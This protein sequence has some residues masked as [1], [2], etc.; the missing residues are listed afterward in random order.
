MHPLVC[1]LN[2]GQ[3]HSSACVA[4]KAEH[5]GDIQAKAQIFKSTN[6]LPDTQ[7]SVSKHR[8]STTLLIN[9]H[10]SATCV[11][12]ECFMLR[13]HRGG[14]CRYLPFQTGTYCRTAFQSVKY[15]MANQPVALY[16]ITVGILS[17]N[18]RICSIAWLVQL[19]EL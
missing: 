12:T 13:G 1:G 6:A 2:Q 9:R 16:A 19:Q 17:H 10:K 4:S 15:S 14:S 8:N 18:N 5:I 11:Q 7:P 3:V